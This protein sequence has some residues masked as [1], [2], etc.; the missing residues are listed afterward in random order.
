MIAER[1]TSFITYSASGAAIIGGITL[2]DWLAFGGFLVALLSA[3]Y[4]VWH[5]REMR[6]IARKAASLE[7]AERVA[8]QD[9]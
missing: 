9:E 4:N 7:D 6:H 2:T 8:E 3:I 5:K 1:T